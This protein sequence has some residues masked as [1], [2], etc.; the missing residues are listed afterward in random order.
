MVSTVT[1]IGPFPQCK[2]L[3]L[4]RSL[5]R[6]PNPC[7]GRMAGWTVYLEENFRT[8]DYKGSGAG[9]VTLTERAILT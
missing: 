3:G 2:I 4:I 5:L 7:L 6:V 8:E 9:Y 1:H